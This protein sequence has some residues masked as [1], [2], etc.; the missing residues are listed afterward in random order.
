MLT[1]KQVDEYFSGGIGSANWKGIGIATFIALCLFGEAKWWSIALGVL[2]V[3]GII[4]YL[5]S[6]Y[7]NI[8]DKQFDDSI[9]ELAK[10]RIEESFDK[11]GIGKDDIVAEPMYIFTYDA[12]EQGLQS[13]I[14]NDGK[15]RC[16]PL[17][18]TIVHFGNNQ[19]LLNTASLDLKNRNKNTGNTN[20]FFYKDI[21]SVSVN[22][23]TITINEKE[24]RT[25]KQFLINVHGSA[26]C[27]VEVIGNVEL[28]T[29]AVS[30]IR[31]MLR[32]KKVSD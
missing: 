2:I 18:L 10:I 30:V 11:L 16:N 31:K 23:S 8:T 17:I 5:I 7:S 9:M 29:N 14:G 21:T 28:A 19:L 22:E 27:N 15:F 12:N 25:V 6:L 4:G 32:Q 24:K 20:E 3:I 1:P 26:E 13:K